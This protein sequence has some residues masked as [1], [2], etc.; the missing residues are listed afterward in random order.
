VE[1]PFVWQQASIKKEK[2]FAAIAAAVAV[3]TC[4]V[5]ATVAVAA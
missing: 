3:A 4:A 5:E 1:N 2:A